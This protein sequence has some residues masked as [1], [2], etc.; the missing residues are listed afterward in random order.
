VADAAWRGFSTEAYLFIAFIYFIFCFSI[1][2]YSQS[3]ERH[4]QTG[5][6]R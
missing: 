4:L 1:S 2:R 3:L 5:H 6:Q